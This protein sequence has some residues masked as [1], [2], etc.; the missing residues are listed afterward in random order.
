VIRN[1][2]DTLLVAPFDAYVSNVA[3]QAG[4]YLS[5][6]DTVAELT[7]IAGLEVKF[8]IAD[9]EFARITQADT[10]VL[11][12]KLTVR[13]RGGGVVMERGATLVRIG[14][15][16]SASTGGVDVYARL[17]KE[18]ANTVFRPGAFVEISLPDRAYPNSARL[19]ESTLYGGNQVFV[20][21]DGRLEARVVTVVGASGDDLFVTGDF[22]PGEAVMTTRLSQAGDGVKVEIR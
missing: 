22:K 10:T 3:A 4:R 11:N 17:D 19:P 8:S 16:I 5:R 9:A 13:W 18:G 15:A 21:V 12:R 20:A 7:D 14:A 2:A 1:L 6:N